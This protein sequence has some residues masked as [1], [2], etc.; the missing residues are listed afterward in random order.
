MYFVGDDLD[1]QHPPCIGLGVATTEYITD[2]P[3]EPGI[4]LPDGVERPVIK[5]ERRPLG[6]HA[7]KAWGFPTNH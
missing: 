6:F 1:G 5:E 3:N 2:K 4:I 7:V